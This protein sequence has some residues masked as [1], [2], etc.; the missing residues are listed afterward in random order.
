MG[1]VGIGV[2][3]RTFHSAVWN[4]LSRRPKRRTVYRGRG[5]SAD[6]DSPLARIFRRPISLDGCRAGGAAHRSVCGDHFGNRTGHWRHRLFYRLLCFWRQL[7]K[8]G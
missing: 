7:V 8:F 5:S 4:R 1:R 2:S 6:F 3:D